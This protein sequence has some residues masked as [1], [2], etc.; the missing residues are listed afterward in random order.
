LDNDVF[1]VDLLKIIPNTRAAF[2]F[3]KKQM[4]SRIRRRSME[5][6]QLYDLDNL[7]SSSDESLSPPPPL[8]PLRPIGNFFIQRYEFL[9]NARRTR[10]DPIYAATPMFTTI[11]SSSSFRIPRQSLSLAMRL[12]NVK[13]TERPNKVTEHD[14]TDGDQQLFS[15]ESTH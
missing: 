6:L 9:C 13:A 4:N 10:L 3:L 1:S 11:P 8:P 2:I 14:E 7:Q 12:P 15:Y 5:Q